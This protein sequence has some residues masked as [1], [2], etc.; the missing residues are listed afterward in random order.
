MLTNHSI[1]LGIAPIGW[2]NDDLPELGGNIPFEQCISEMA[3][4][5]FEGCEVGN[6]FPRDPK[7]LRHSLELRG[8]SIA[9]AWFSSYL[10]TKPYEETEVAFIAHRDFLR[11]MGAKHIVIS[12]QGHSIQGDQT[13]PILENKPIFSEKEWEMLVEGLD[14]LGQLASEKG[15]TLVYHHHMGTGIQSEEEINRLMER[16]NPNYVSLL[17]DCGHLYFAGEDYLSVLR[18]HIDRIA[19][20]HFKDVRD[21]VLKNVKEERLS[22]LDGI[23]EGVFTVPGDGVINFKAI[24]Q[25]IAQSNYKG[26]IIVEA[27]QDPAKANPFEYAKNA[28]Q[29][30]R[31]IANL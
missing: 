22:F 9:A 17:Y 7:V 10:T 4:A 31:E 20:I 28:R 14:K 25:L 24:I 15:M 11:E 30:I 21:V 8:L 3:L 19:H 5:G 27:E 6:K 13:S 2:T 1:K 29:Y 18:N 23:K 12:E 26:W 16:T